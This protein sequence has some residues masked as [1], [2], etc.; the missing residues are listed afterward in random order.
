MK[1]IIGNSNNE[2]IHYNCGGAIS[3]KKFYH[4]EDVLFCTKCNA[5]MFLSYCND[6]Y[7]SEFPPSANIEQNIEAW[8]NGRLSSHQN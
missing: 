6:I 1:N 7:N 4:T 3:F 2:G 8:N 5:F